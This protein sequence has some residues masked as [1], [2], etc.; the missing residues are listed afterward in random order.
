MTRNQKASY[1]RYTGNHPN[2]EDCS[3]V[4]PYGYP[5]DLVQWMA[6]YTPEGTKVTGSKGDGFGNEVHVAAPKEAW[7]SEWVKMAYSYGADIQ[8]DKI[9]KDE[10]GLVWG[11]T[12]MLYDEPDDQTELFFISEDQTELEMIQAGYAPLS[13]FIEGDRLWVPCKGVAK[14]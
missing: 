4:N 10:D 2:G 5:L 11:I 13:E 8:F 7:E 3:R 1:W 12:T 6:F 14:V 9:E